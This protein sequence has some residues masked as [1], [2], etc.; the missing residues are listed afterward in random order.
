MCLR[1]RFVIFFW[2]EIGV[3]AAH[4]MLV[5]L[6][7]GLQNSTFSIFRRK[8]LSPLQVL[9]F[10]WSVILIIVT[11]HKHSILPF[12][13]LCCCYFIHFIARSQGALGR[14]RK[15]LNGMFL[16]SNFPQFC[17]RGVGGATLCNFM[18]FRYYCKLVEWLYKYKFVYS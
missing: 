11:L 15:G 6:T 2:K 7:K 9:V 5:K 16:F 3:K 14:V 10:I 4:K 8:G 13:Y 1:L 17:W 18:T 12:A